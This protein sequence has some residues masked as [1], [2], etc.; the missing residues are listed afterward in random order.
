VVVCD[1]TSVNLF[2]L[3]A[4][5]VGRG[6]RSGRTRIVTSDDNFPTDLYVAEGVAQLAG[7]EVSRAGASA[8]D[9]QTAALT[10]SHVDYR[11][12]RMLDMAGLTTA[13]HG[14]GA[15][16]VWDLSHSAGAVPL[17]LDAW[18][19]DLAVGCTYKFLNCGPGAPAFLYVARRLQA[20]LANFAR[21]WFGHADPFAFA[22]DYRPAPG[23]GRFLSG[24][25]GVIGMAPV[26]AA[27]EAW[28]GVS[29]HDV[30]R[31]SVAIADL[32]MTRLDALG[33]EVASPRAAVERGSQV[34]VHSQEGYGLSRALGEEGV[35]TDFR[36]PDIVRL[37]I[38]P[39]YLRYVDAWDAM[40]TL[41]SVL[42]AGTHQDAR[43]RERARFP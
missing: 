23:I 40:D 14:A 19:V 4:A 16:V 35:V 21:G 9:A 38:T 24:T 43:W 1:S 3:L 34:S 2:K 33:L 13:S 31:K 25:P 27:L 8:C 7:A 20:E 26:A 41:E 17:E 11:T 39:L 37:G 22:P 28:A 18:D 10:L 15:L 42:S 29:M 32:L 30:R 6:R 5:A 36:P 12:G